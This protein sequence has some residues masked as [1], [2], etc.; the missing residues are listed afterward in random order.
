MQTSTKIEIFDLVKIPP[1]SK[2]LKLLYGTYV[3]CL[4]LNL[5]EIRPLEHRAGLLVHPVEPFEIGI[6]CGDILDL[7]GDPK[8]LETFVFV[9]FS[10]SLGAQN[11]YYCQIKAEILKVAF[12][13]SCI[14]RYRLS[15]PLTSLS[16]PLNA[17]FPGLNMWDTIAFDCF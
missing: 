2:S 10:K 16:C 11:R 15:K 5:P 1:L 8:V 13:N 6:S 12:F 3:I 7:Q 4:P 17:V 14:L 9:I